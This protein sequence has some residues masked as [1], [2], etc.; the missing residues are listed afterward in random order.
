MIAKSSNP[1]PNAWELLEK[2]ED[3]VKLYIDTYQTHIKKLRSASALY[4]C[5]VGSFAYAALYRVVFKYNILLD[6]YDWE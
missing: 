1:S 4:G 5:L 2:D 3:Q 6:K